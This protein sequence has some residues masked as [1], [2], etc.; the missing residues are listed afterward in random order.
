MLLK[1]LFLVIFFGNGNKV[2]ATGLP[3]ENFDMLEIVEV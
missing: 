3:L 1:E 2:F